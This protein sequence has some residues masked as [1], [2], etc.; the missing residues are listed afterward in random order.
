VTLKLLTEGEKLPLD[1]CLK[2][3]YRMSQRFMAEHDF[4]EGVRAILIDK[5]RQPVWSPRTLGEVSENTVNSYFLPLGKDEKEL[6]F[7]SF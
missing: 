2:I 3:E 4:H 1:E 7:S 6:D 5:D